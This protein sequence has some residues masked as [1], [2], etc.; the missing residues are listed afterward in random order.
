MRIL[1]RYILREVLTHGLL[2]T[3]LFTFVLFM[4]DAGRIL[5]LAVR[6]SAPLPSV[7]EIFFLTL[8]T[9]LN[10]TLP[11]GVLVGIL[12][13]LSRLAADSE[14]TAMR[15]SGL[16]AA[17]FLRTLAWFAA[18]V[19]LFA[20]WNSVYLAPRSAA[21]LSRLQDALKNAQVSF[22][23]QPRVFYEGFKDSV[24]YV[25]DS[26][27]GEGVATW[28]GIFLADLSNPSTPRITTAKQG[29]LV[30]ESSTL[31]HLHLEQG[32]QHEAQSHQ[33]QQ[34]AI[35]TFND[36]DIPIQGSVSDAPARELLPTAEM[37]TADLF[38]AARSAGGGAATW[39]WIELHRRLALPA[40]CLVLALLGIPLGLS[41]KKGGK[42]T[43]FVLTVALVFIYYVIS[44]FGVALAR[45]QKI[46]PWA[47]VWMA[48][49]IFLAAGAA[50]FWRVN[51]QPLEL[52]SPVRL[53]DAWKAYFSAKPKYGRA[54][55]F[56]RARSRR[57]MFSARFPQ[58]LDDY[59]IRDFLTYLL[60]VLST[61][62]LLTVVFTFFELLGDI[63][64][65][66]VPL[67]TVG[68]YLMRVAPSMLYL[69]TPLCVLVAVLITFGLMEKSHE[70]T[71]MKASGISVYRLLAPVLL[72]ATGM[73]AGLFFFDQVYLPD[74]NKRREA[75]RNS[76]KGKPAQTFL[77]ADRKWIFGKNSTIYYYEFFDPDQN[78]F[79]SVS[80]FEFD[81]ASFAMTRR[82]YA[83]RAHWDEDLSKWVFQQGW[84][85]SFRGAAIQEFR[86]FDVAT[87]EE[88]NE[89]PAYFK[90]EVK[91]SEEM[92]YDELAR[93]IAD[94][95]NSGF[96][97]GRLSIQL[98][99][100]FSFPLV[101]L[102][103]AVLA[104]PFSLSAG[105]RGALTGVAVA[106]G[107]FL[108]YWVISSFFEALGNIHY[109][110]P[111]VAA[112]SPDVIFAL[113]GGYLILK[114][115]T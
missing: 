12:I 113:A 108:V 77:R 85:R 65:N 87:F 33:A 69:V 84:V 112:W 36:T 9:A 29:V 104:V 6:N 97:V 22:E 11:M 82:F 21:A 47:G 57:R 20:S 31:M 14:V 66:R 83:A 72:L 5:E 18:A 94:L 8:P 45:Q 2:G 16:G 114:V 44:L 30:N 90:K 96:D 32:S 98:H 50:L 76:I 61:L 101:T 99:K 48:N 91:Q 1:P 4:R 106:L 115:P 75:L 79:A 92:N 49:V 43:G 78:R 27:P 25:Q 10:V 86:N 35:S 40:S 71:A 95:Q 73:S 52:G 105:R 100:K 70:V 24:I 109:L 51:K 64:R 38:G 80:V 37:T 89:P 88:L 41:A 26:T 17:L 34:Y 23:V 93:Y 81:P 74:N 3:A 56:G 62:V 111:V 67:V 42:A 107:I 103:M 39:Y 7:A 68:E 58:I 63:V 28:Q 54:D 19:W 13:G 110:P 46:A 55:A 102:V 59:V 15:A 60:L 53:W